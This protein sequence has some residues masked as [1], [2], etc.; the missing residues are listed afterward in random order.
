[1]DNWKTKDK[2]I[3]MENLKKGILFRSAR[4]LAF[5]DIQNRYIGPLNYYYTKYFDHDK[6]LDLIY[7]KY[8]ESDLKIFFRLYEE[9]KLKLLKR[10]NELDIHPPY[11]GDIRTQG[12]S[13]FKKKFE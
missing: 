13:L 11:K 9:Y 10:K 6:E 2:N 7:R 8:K 5:L 3:L 1:M 12:N 4:F